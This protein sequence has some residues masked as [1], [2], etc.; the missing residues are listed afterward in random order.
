MSLFESLAVCKPSVGGHVWR[1][2]EENVQVSALN[3]GAERPAGPG[4][5]DLLTT[6]LG[7]TQEL[8]ISPAQLPGFLEVVSLLLHTHLLR[9]LWQRKFYCCFAHY[10]FLC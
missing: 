5:D 4:P 6:W 2:E 7:P 1:W 9:W 10:L 8:G 3:V